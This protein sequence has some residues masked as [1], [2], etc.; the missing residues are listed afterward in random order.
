MSVGLPG[1]VPGPFLPSVEKLAF[2]LER[3]W[4]ARDGAW[5]AALDLSNR[6]ETGQDGET[7]DDPSDSL[8]VGWDS[9]R[10]QAGV[11]VNVDRDDGAAVAIS[12]DAKAP[13]KGKGGAGGEV[14]YARS[15]CQTV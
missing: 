9:T 5:A 14:R 15:G 7:I 13:G 11:T 12:V 3:R 10:L 6:I 1:F 4:P 2:A 8:S